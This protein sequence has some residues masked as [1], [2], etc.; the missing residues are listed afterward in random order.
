MLVISIVQK[1]F[2]FLGEWD[3][4]PNIPVWTVQKLSVLQII[5]VGFVGIP[6]THFFLLQEVKL[7]K[8]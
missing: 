6:P 1:L 3:W 7:S 5:S 4:L 8:L 2:L